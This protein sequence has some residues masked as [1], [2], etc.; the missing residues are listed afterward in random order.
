[1]TAYAIIITI[2]FW[3]QFALV[4]IYADKLRKKEREVLRSENLVIPVVAV[5]DVHGEDFMVDGRAEEKVG[6]ELLLK[7]SERGCVRVYHAHNVRNCT[8]TVTCVVLAKP[9]NLN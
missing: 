2:A 3:I 5:T 4:M 6:A 7:L 8:T 1:M 9:L